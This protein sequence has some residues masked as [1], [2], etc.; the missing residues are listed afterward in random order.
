MREF[1]IFG[2]GNIGK[3]ALEFYGM[4]KV[5]CIVD[6]DIN[7]INTYLEGK[8]IIC[9]E[10]LKRIS[11]RYTIVIALANYVDVV[12]QLH[13]MNIENYFVFRE[14]FER[15][16][17]SISLYDN[18]DFY[19]ILCG[20]DETTVGIEDIIKRKGYTYRS[21]AN[22]EDIKNFNV[23]LRNIDT[24][25]GKSPLFLVS[26]YK[27]RF[28]VETVIEQS[29]P[30]FIIINP[31]VQTRF[32]NENV[33]LIDSYKYDKSIKTEEEWN[34]CNENNIKSQRNQ[35]KDYVDTVKENPVL[36][37]Y[38]EIET[39]NRCN[40]TCSFCPVNK[41]VDS[42]KEQKM[43]ITLFKK[44]INELHDMEY[45]GH[46]ALF[47]N[48]EPLL[49]ERIVEMN[50]YARG[51]L[52]QA[53]I[54]LF[55]NGILLNIELLEKLLPD[56]DELIIDNYSERLKMIKPVERIYEYV[57]DKPD[58]KN[59]IAIVIRDPQEV[60]TTRGGDSPNRNNILSYPN[61]TCALPFRQMVIRPDGR[62]SLCCN[63]PLGKMT[64]GRLDKQSIKEVWFGTAYSEI[65]KKIANG[66]DNI[67]HCS[68]CDTFY[69]Y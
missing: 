53:T 26:T 69:L 24:Y 18:K 40:G 35:I 37:K 15:L 61:D 29:Q 31:Y 20:R 43:E 3:K 32:Y 28:S 6:N 1:I 21:L 56:L 64:L 60:L 44:I 50:H 27:Q 45:Q 41:L 67:E 33:F 11:D 12:R 68:R 10:E 54:Y 39:F 38:I 59:K 36:F 14:E 17:E 63:D 62:V 23:K 9:V 65:R 16:E 2:A 22:K 49:D 4:D 48:N 7:K 5:Y 57:S 30:G 47:S 8:K 19:F 13:A 51:M 66:R 34:R 58:M 42:R 46:L 25:V 52:P 55:T